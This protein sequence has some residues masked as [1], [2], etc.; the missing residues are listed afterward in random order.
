[1]FT[2]DN[3]RGVR[4]PARTTYLSSSLSACR[5]RTPAQW[6][7]SLWL[8][9]IQARTMP[10]CLCLSLSHIQVSGAS[11]YP[12]SHSFYHSL[13]V[14]ASLSNGRFY[15]GSTCAHIVRCRPSPLL[16]LPP[17]A[18]SV[19][20]GVKWSA[21]FVFALATFLASLLFRFMAYQSLI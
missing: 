19:S 14:C 21:I 18:S 2:V 4:D 1:M 17:L 13:S 20:K 7:Q 15:L 11:L 9:R 3:A 12:H 16:W 5:N 10:G 6:G 8:C